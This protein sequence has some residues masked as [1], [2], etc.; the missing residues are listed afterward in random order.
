MLFVQLN[1][2]VLVP[3]KLVLGYNFHATRTHDYKDKHHIF[4]YSKDIL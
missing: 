2:S 3:F 1:D 4:L